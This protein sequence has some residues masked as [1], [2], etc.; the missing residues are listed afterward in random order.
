MH[1]RLLR[2]MSLTQTVCKEV[3]FFFQ[4]MQIVLI[5]TALNIQHAGKGIRMFHENAKNVQVSK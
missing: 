2:V 5:Q 3:T 1:L 4:I